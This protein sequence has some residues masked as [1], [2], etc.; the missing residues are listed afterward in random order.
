MKIMKPLR[1]SLQM[2]SS[3][4]AG[5]I[6]RRPRI[7]RPQELGLVIVVLALG[8]LL[9]LLADPVRGENGFLRPSNL[10]PSVFTTMSWTAIMAVGMTAVI[11]SGGID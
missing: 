11:I 1:M 7:A 10:I 5:A 4:T 8:T 2:S 3:E 9:A 6:K